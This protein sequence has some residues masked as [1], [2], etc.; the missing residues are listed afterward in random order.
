M[1]ISEV[2]NCFIYQ[3]SMPVLSMV[4]A[5]AFFTIFFL[6]LGARFLPFLGPAALPNLPGL[7]PNLPPL[8]GLPG[9]PPNDF[10]FAGLR[11][12]NIGIKTPVYFLVCH[13]NLDGAKLR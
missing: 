10:F 2:I 12:L 5:G 6:R 1:G 9:F 7:P 3:A 11:P 4:C 13:P 8:P